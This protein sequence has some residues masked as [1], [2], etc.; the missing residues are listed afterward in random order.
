MLT[1]TLI[2]RDSTH[3]LIVC[4]TF[5]HIASLGIIPRFL[6]C[7]FCCCV[8][9]QQWFVCMY[10]KQIGLGFWSAKCSLLA[11][12]KVKYIFASP[13]NNPSEHF[14]TDSNVVYAL[15]F[16]VCVIFNNNTTLPRWLQ[17]W[18]GNHHHHR[19][20]LRACSYLAMM[21]ATTR[22][23]R[24]KTKAK[25]RRPLSKQDFE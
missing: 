7:C 13:K 17:L 12:S 5:R 6:C 9:Y 1:Y 21:N 23:N 25:K 20:H 11:Q 22:A 24:E 3:N 8:L 4:L 10:I 18:T 19:T 16:C 2:G 15:Y 14:R